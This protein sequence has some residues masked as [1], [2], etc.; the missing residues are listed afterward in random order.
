[1]AR[2]R[3]HARSRQET[4]EGRFLAARIQDARRRGATNREIADAFGINERTVRKIVSGE[5]T[6]RGTFRRLVEPT[7]RAAQGSPNPS[8][9]RVDL[10]VTYA[11]GTT[12]TRSVNARVPTIR[13]ARGDRVTPTPADVFRLPGAIE[14]ATAEADRLARQY[15]QSLAHAR[16]TALRPILHRR[17]PLRFTIGGTLA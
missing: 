5:S 2:R 7:Q 1:M 3:A 10:Q 12:E 9:V 17:A 4:S 16:V 11:D 14:A 13:T 8:I 6:G 15:G